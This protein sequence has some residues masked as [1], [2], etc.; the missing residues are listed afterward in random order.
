MD[1]SLTCCAT[2]SSCMKA[3]TREWV[4][5]AEEDFLAASAFEPSAEEASVE[6]RLFSRSTDSGEISE[7][8]AR[9]SRVRHPE[10]SRFTTPAESRRCRRAALVRLPLC[11][12][13]A[14][15]LCGSD[16]VP[17]EF[18]DQI[19]CAA[20]RKALSAIPERGTTSSGTAITQ[21]PP[22]STSPKRNRQDRRGSL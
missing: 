8:S 15:Q 12:Q 2:A 22:A 9:R 18:C 11:L 19:R 6:C 4:L 16:A 5:K 7:G 3:S 14:R 10:D 1:S 21:K 13:L 20:C 17:G